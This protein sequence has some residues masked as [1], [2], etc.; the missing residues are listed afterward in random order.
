MSERTRG[1]R[2]E[3]R[4]LRRRWRNGRLLCALIEAL[5]WAAA[6]VAVLAWL[7]LL[8]ALNGAARAA[9]G[10]A[11]ALLLLGWVA[12]RLG[13]AWSLTLRDTAVYADGLLH[14][15]RREALSALELQRSLAPGTS[16]L[17]TYFVGACVDRAATRMKSVR[18]PW[19]AA[20]WR[21]ARRRLALCLAVALLPGLV[22]PRAAWTVTRRVIFPHADIPPYSRYRFEI[23]PADPRVVY[24]ADQDITVTVRGARVRRAVEFVTRC[25]GRTRASACFQAGPAEFAQRIEHVMQPVEFCFR[26]GRARSRWHRVAVLLQPRVTGARIRMTPPAYSRLR[27][28]EFA[29]GERPIEGLHGSR[30]ALTVQSNRPLRGGRLTLTPSD[31]RAHARELPGS[32]VGPTTAS[33]EWEIRQN[34]TVRVTVSDILGTDCR[35]PLVIRQELVPDEPPA[36]TLS[37]PPLFCLATPSVSVPVEGVVDDDLGIRR[38]D[39]VRA[40]AGY[41]DRAYPLDHQPG[42]RTCEV[43]HKL[44]LGLLGVNPGQVI[45]LLLEATDTNPHLTGVGA[46]DIARVRI[47]SDDEYARMLRV[48]TTI[49]QFD[50]RF[51]EVVAARNEL[52][53]QMEALRKALR[54]GKLTPQEGKQQMDELRRQAQE[55]ADRL[56]ELAAE[57][58]AYD[59]E[60]SLA[61]TADRMA[62]EIRESLRHFGWEGANVPAMEAAL[63]KCM[64]ALGADPQSGDRLAELAGQ[65]D[66]IARVARLMDCASWY[67]ALVQRQELLVRRLQRFAAGERDVLDPGRMA[68]TQDE[69]RKELLAL[70]SELERRASDLPAAYAELRDS[71][72]AFLAAMRE[73]DI[74]APMTACA[75]ACRGR[76]AREA[77]TQG[78]TA[79]ERMK[80]LLS[81]CKGGMGGL[82]RGDIKFAVPGYLEATMTQMLESLMARYAASV[83][84]GRIGAAGMG[85]LGA[86]QGST[87]AGMSP[88]EVPVYGPQRRNP[89]N[90]SAGRGGRDG[91]GAPGV[92]SVRRA[93]VTETVESDERKRPTGEALDMEIVPP[94]YRAA[95]RAFYGEESP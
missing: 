28:A 38:A 92:G 1:F 67:S 71:A 60:R 21:A 74:P 91:E 76:K 6:A 82:C 64:A 56:T 5:G 41:R 26:L 10:I 61:D 42:A 54:E 83:G 72:L 22:N 94:R 45:E 51:S 48:R 31:G 59:L 47:I 33:F 23:T 39:V 50:A 69:I 9:L 18:D 90:M 46:S 14:S 58:A 2:A 86:S 49:E 80:E 17:T 37:A 79:L 43:S 85:V 68:D 36:A 81:S 55:F 24:G 75:A 66:E 53:E 29:L 27:P 19:P 65:A 3:L 95:V 12:F 34:A 62:G 20:E 70:A 30:V 87:L 40:L 63:E 8:L 73:L 32:V 11:A 13:R 25:G 77:W 78:L 88:L 89:F 7:D 52:L 4:R 16:S 84:V 35:K 93:A 57:F 15:R 44:D